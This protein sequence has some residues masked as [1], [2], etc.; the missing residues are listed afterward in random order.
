MSWHLKLFVDRKLLVGRKVGGQKVFYPQ[1]M[2]DRTA[3][4]IL[5]LL[6]NPKINRIFIS[7]IK[8]P[9]I[10]QKQLSVQQKLSHQSIYSFINRIIDE[11]LVKI[12]KDGKF[13]RYF[14]TTKINQLQIAQRKSTKEFKTWVIKALKFDGVDPKLIRVTD[15]LLLIQIQ[16]GAE[17]ESMKLSVNP[18]YSIVQNKK[19][20]LAEL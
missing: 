3:V 13:T 16:A 8:T 11:G 12:I 4:P 14:P 15:K 20:F 5:S 10:S 7:V 18:F 2:F 19:Q 9:G 6:G 1:N 17:I